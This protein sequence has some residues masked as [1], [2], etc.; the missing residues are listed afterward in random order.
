MKKLALSASL[1]LAA[2]GA[3]LAQVD[4]RGI[5]LEGL[6]RPVG[7]FPGLYDV[8]RDTVGTE[9]GRV[10]S[11]TYFMRDDEAD[12]GN[13]LYTAT[14]I[15][16]APGTFHADSTAR[17]EAFFRSTVTAAAEAV[18][19]EV[20]IS[21]PVDRSDDV[22]AW[23]FRIDYAAGGQPATVRNLAFLRGDRYYHL[24][25]FSLKSDAG[26]R[27]RERFFESFRPVPAP[28]TDG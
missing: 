4:W 11:T 6:E 28:S 12:S 1:A 26:T 25:V 23:T 3:S 27:A 5:E 13:R 14:V 20:L 22:P 7:Y 2:C 21:Q 17:R 19:G 15:D 10:P 8:A 16:F 18:E 9:L 24:Q